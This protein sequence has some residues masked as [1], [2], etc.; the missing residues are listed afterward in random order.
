MLTLCACGCGDPAPL[1]QRTNQRKGHVKGQPLLFVSGHNTRAI[2]PLRRV[3]RGPT[4]WTWI[5]GHSRKGYG[6][7]QV[8]RTHTGAHRVVYELLVGPIPRGHDLDHLCRNTGCVNPAHLEPVTPEEN[9]RR[10]TLRA[11]GVTVH[12][13]DPALVTT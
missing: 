11:A 5:G 12:P 9:R 7:C 2:D 13:D 6:R 4:C 10:Q 8:N 3:V 1:A